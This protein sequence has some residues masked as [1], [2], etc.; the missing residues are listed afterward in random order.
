M[1][2]PVITILASAALLSAC[3]Q[4]GSVNE[5]VAGSAIAGAVVGAV[6]GAIIGDRKGAAIGAGI[7][8]IA[9]AGV[10]G[11]LDAQQRELEENLEGTGATVTNTG[12]ELFVNLPSEV[13][14]DVDRAEIKPEFRPSLIKVAETLNEYESSVVDV[15]GHTDSTGSD[16]YNQRLSE[17]RAETVANLFTRRG[18]APVRI[19]AYG[20]GEDAPIASNDTE[21]GRLANRRVEFRRTDNAT[22]P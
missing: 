6:A 9:G 21:A 8:A 11:Y 17:R 16:A 20:R 19:E 22:S 2:R 1:Q 5:T 12:E 7:G 15:I 18:V 4:D 14:F 13:T 3:A 10:G